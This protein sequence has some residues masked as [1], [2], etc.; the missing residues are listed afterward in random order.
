MFL[1]SIYL[2][3]PISPLL[4]HSTMKKVKNNF[5]IQKKILWNYTFGQDFPAITAS[6]SS[7]VPENGPDE[8]SLMVHMAAAKH[9][10][11]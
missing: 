8:A 10:L 6:M 7:G 1:L 11:S 9:P 5:V 3:N 4:V 2:F